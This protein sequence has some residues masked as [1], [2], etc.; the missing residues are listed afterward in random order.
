MEVEQEDG[1]I[2]MSSFTST[3]RSDTYVQE[4]LDEYKNHIKLDLKPKQTP[5]QRGDILTN[6][7]SGCPETPDP[8]EQ[9]RKFYR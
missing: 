6:D 7:D 8:K 5:M 2:T 3:R 1:C 9:T 4:M